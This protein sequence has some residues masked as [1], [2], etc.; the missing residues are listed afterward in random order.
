M[1]KGFS[2]GIFGKRYRF[3]TGLVH[4]FKNT[5]YHLNRMF[6]VSPEQLGGVQIATSNNSQNYDDDIDFMDELEVRNHRRY[7]AEMERD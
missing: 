5:L 7:V 1:G 6:G 2:V 4:A 3:N